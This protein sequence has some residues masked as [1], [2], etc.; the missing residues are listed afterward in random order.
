MK[1][2][3]GFVS[4]S[5]STSFLVAWDKRVEKITDVSKYI[6]NPAQARMLFDWMREQGGL[7]MCAPPKTECKTCKERFRCYTGD[8]KLDELAKLIGGGGYGDDLD[9]EEYEEES[10][11]M[12]KAIEFFK[13]NKG[14]VAYCFRI[15]DGG[16]GASEVESGMRCGDVFDGVIPYDA[17]E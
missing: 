3:E 4:N 6:K 9:D 15:G 1:I 7:Y 12:G 17:W 13:K 2:R 14:R 16:E 5:S 10:W 11:S 8:G